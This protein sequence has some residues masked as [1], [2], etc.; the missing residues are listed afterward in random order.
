MLLVTPTFFTF[1]GPRGRNV[2]DTLPPLTT[3]LVCVAR[4]SQVVCHIARGEARHIFYLYVFFLF[5]FDLVL[6]FLFY[7]VVFCLFPSVTNA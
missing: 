3:G 7:F 6:C 5:L 4:S 1:C 2:N